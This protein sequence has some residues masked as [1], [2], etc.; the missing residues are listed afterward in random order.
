MKYISYLLIF[1]TII[2]CTSNTI[3][4]K[5]KDLIPRDSM[6]LMLQDLYTANAA[7][8]VKNKF[9]NKHKTYI[10]FLYEKYKVDSLRFFES[11]NYYNSQINVY[12][13]M[14]NEVRLNLQIQLDSFSDQLHVKDSIKDA[15]KEIKK[16]KK[17]RKDSITKAARKNRKL[18]DSIKEQSQLLKDSIEGYEENE[19]ILDSITKIAEKSSKL[20]DSI[21]EQTRI[22]DSIINSEEE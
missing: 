16:E 21:H 22:K 17:R 2:S 11:N 10:P 9:R 5:P 13:E 12:E 6:V 15:E 20:L 1:I 19:D 4:K 18:L 14:L 3:Y 8:S 7:K